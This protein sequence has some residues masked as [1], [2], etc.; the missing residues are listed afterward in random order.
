MQ[1][2]GQSGRQSLCKG[3]SLS[4][5]RHCWQTAEGAHSLWQY[6]LRTDAT[7]TVQWQGS[8]GQYRPLAGCRQIAAVQANLQTPREEFV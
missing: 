3:P 2:Y 7:H 6:G 8:V 1:H 4:S 5:C